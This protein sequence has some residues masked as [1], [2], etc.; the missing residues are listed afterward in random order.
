MASTK[1][2]AAG[3]VLWFGVIGPHELLREV[4]EAGLRAQSR[5]LDKLDEEYEGIVKVDD[6]YVSTDKESRIGKTLRLLAELGVTDDDDLRGGVRRSLGASEMVPR[7]RRAEVAAKT[8]GVLRPF[9]ETWRPLRRN[10]MGEDR[11]LAEYLARATGGVMKRDDLEEWIRTHTRFEDG[12]R[13]TYSPVLEMVANGVFG[14]RGAE[15]DVAAVEAL[16]NASPGPWSR[17]GRLDRQRIW[18]EVRT[19]GQQIR[20]RIPAD[21]REAL[22]ERTWEL[23]TIAGGQLGSLRVAG[24]RSVLVEWAHQAPSDWA[25]GEHGAVLEFDTTHSRVTLLPGASSSDQFDHRFVDGCALINGR[26][27]FIFV[28]DKHAAATGSVSI[29]RAVSGLGEI[30]YGRDTIFEGDEGITLTVSREPHACR[31]SGLELLMTRVEVGSYIRLGFGTDKCEIAVA[32]PPEQPADTLSRYAGVFVTPVNLWPTIGKAMGVSSANRQKVR[33]IL[34]ERERFDLNSILDA[35]ANTPIVPPPIVIPSSAFYVQNSTLLRQD[36]GDVLYA[37]RA[38]GNGLFGL[39]WNSGSV[40]M[41]RDETWA[42]RSLLV[43]RAWAAAASCSDEVLFSRVDD[44]WISNLG[45]FPTIRD[46]LERLACLEGELPLASIGWHEPMLPLKSL[47]YATAF[48]SAETRLRALRI[49]ADGWTGF[50]HKG[51]ECGPTPL[52]SLLA[53][54]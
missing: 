48:S 21:C 54:S 39:V 14:V 45:R 40:S 8:L 17:W 46:G 51:G 30:A 26:W 6:F 20:V 25:A 41:T 7:A 34:A 42:Q 49:N 28:V 16:R 1:D 24:E 35:A 23:R 52:R 31:V 19:A 50:A 43:I 9:L 12:V 4:R 22:E 11:A 27:Q 15:V 29:P 13:L 32:D 44:G 37:E 3:L 53:G 5:Y 18:I 2:Y 36:S 33:E 47:G 38:A 10:E